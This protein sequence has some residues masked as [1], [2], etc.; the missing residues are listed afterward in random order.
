MELLLL[1]VFAA[2]LIQAGRAIFGREEGTLEQRKS[3]PSLNTG[4]WDLHQR[5]LSI[6]K[7][8]KF[9]GCHYYIGPRG[10]V[11]YINSNGRKTYC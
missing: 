3:N 9:K 5:R 2:I 7:H 4:N 10:G 1:L 6:Y 11:Y 8:S